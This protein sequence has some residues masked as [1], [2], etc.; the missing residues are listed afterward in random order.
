MSVDLPAEF[1]LDRARAGAFLQTLG[2]EYE[3]VTT[4]TVVAH[5]DVSADHHTP[6]GIVHGGFYAAVIETV[7][8]VGASYAVLSNGQFSVGV[9]NQTDFLRPFVEGRL[10]VQATAVSQGRN[11]QLWLVELTNADG[12]LIARGQVRLFN[13]AR[14]A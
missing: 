3:S 7:A 5:V 10:N 6:W 9:N 13:Q 8:S 2:V 1:D 14:P 12:K 4:S 11:L